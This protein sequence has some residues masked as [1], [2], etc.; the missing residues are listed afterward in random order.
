MSD[1]TESLGSAREKRRRE[2]L[3]EANPSLPTVRDVPG[4]LP[5]MVDESEAALIA[6]DQGIYRRGG[7]IVRPYIEEV[8]GANGTVTSSYRTARLGEAALGEAFTRAA[9]FESYD[10]RSRRFERCNCPH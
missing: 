9:N 2:A 7:I 5:R 8:P 6:S 3:G 10:A 4:E 1:D